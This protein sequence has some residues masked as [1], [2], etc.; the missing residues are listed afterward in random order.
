M[1]SGA[2]SVERPDSVMSG[3]L[4]SDGQLQRLKRLRG[5]T[6]E[7]EDD[8]F[9]QI[10]RRP[11]RVRVL[12]QSENVAS[13]I[14]E[15]STPDLLERDKSYYDVCVTSS[16]HPLPK[17]IGFAKLLSNMEIPEILKIKYKSA[18]RAI[19]TFEN[20]QNAEKLTKS[21]IFIEK[22][23]R[24]QRTDQMNLC[25][26]IV[27]QIDLETDVEELHRSFKCEH[28]IVSI[29]RLKRQTGDGAWTDSETVRLCVRGST[30]PAYVTAYGCRFMVDA[31]TF[32]VSQCAGCWL[33][34][35]IKK[36]CPTKRIVCPKCGANHENCETK[37]FKCVNC[38]GQ[39][40]CR[41]RSRSARL[42]KK[43]KKYAD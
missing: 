41:L 13:S 6:S 7:N 22:G 12:K 30:L 27:R 38:K 36:F 11:R 21:E 3:D 37:N 23:F 42:L 32:P 35:H 4:F 2:E 8:G 25:Y 31:Y 14:G 24:C 39:L 26:G 10:K 18:Y 34:G 33:Y 15:R 40:I 29:R 5:E 17:Q 16:E 9:V 1:V 20:E 19:V 28:E 43:K